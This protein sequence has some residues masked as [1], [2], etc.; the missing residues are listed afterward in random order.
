MKNLKKI[1]IVLLV[2]SITYLG[3]GWESSFA[4][5]GGKDDF[6]IKYKIENETTQDNK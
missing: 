2:S 5:E 4:D 3:M 1:L 6:P